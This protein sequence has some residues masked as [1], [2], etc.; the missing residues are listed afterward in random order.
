MCMLAYDLQLERVAC[1]IRST[2]IVL[3]LYTCLAINQLKAK[4]S[5]VMVQLLL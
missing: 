5:I 3:H 4:T 1:L 2:V